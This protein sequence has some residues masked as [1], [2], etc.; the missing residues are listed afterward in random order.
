MQYRSFTNDNLQVSALGFGCMRL[1]CLTSGKP[2][3]RESVRMIHHAIENGVN[4]FDTAYPYHDGASEEIVGKAL[5][6]KYRENVLLAT[7][8]PTWEATS[9]SKLDKIFNEQLTKLQ[10]DHV[11]MYMLHCLQKSLMPNVEKYNLIDWLE[12]KRKQGK[13]RYV[14]FSF[15]DELALFKEIVDMH[16][17]DFCQIQYNYVGENVQAGTEGLHYAAA[18]GISVIIMEPLLGGALAKPNGKLAGIWEK[19]K[20]NHVDLALR[21]LWD[22]P[23]VGIV[24]SGMSSMEQLVD[25]IRYADKAKVNSLTKTEHA[26]IVK[27]QNTYHKMTPVRCTKCKYCIPCPVGVDIPTN[28]SLYNDAVAAPAAKT[29]GHNLYVMMSGESRASNCKACGAC[30]KKCPQHLPIVKRLKDVAKL[31]G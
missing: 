30:E 27:A 2:N 10:T 22:K 8:F 29:L 3:R 23:E 25:N 4:Y 14:G 21:W 6:G 13:I 26:F 1:P 19:N 7:K 18:R 20:Y 17:W 28:F 16:K 11:D 15:H 5:A 9:Q 12:K 31:L 24:L